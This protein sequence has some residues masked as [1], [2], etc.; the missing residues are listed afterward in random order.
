MYFLGVSRTQGSGQWEAKALEVQGK[1]ATE[2]HAPEKRGPCTH[3]STSHFRR[4]FF[5]MRA[6]CPTQSCTWLM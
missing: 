5:D 3:E 1:G 4:W 2:A 6:A